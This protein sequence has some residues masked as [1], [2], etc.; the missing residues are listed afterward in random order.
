[1][2]EVHAAT[3]VR[4]ANWVVEGV[5]DDFDCTVGGLVPAVFEHYVRVFHPASRDERLGDE[6]IEVRWADVASAN[7]RTMHPAAEWGSLTGSWQL[8]GQPDL[9]DHPPRVGELPQRL[10]EQLAE[11]L[12]PFTERADRCFFG[13]WE[14]WGTPG[15]LILFKQ[16]TPEAEQRESH[17][18]ANAEIRTQREFLDCAPT[19]TLPHR[20]IQLVEGPLG[21]ISAFYENYRDPPSLW[22]PE[23]RAW[24]VA[25]DIDVMSTYVGGSHDVIQTLL[26]DER[27]EVLLVPVDQ[28]VTW[29]AD[30]INPLPK[31]PS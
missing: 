28:S 21:A 23:D 25:T 13:V 8:D 20:G 5:R 24:C 11:A 2:P 31:P 19:F 12:A 7:S 1:M 26:S 10:A 3:D 27:L 9:W 14:G 22:W 6:S 17:E 29:E 30:T 4:A 18:S 15:A 16:G